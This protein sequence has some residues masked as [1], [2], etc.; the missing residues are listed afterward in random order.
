[1]ILRIKS[2]ID[3]LKTIQAFK[4]V[5]GVAEFSTDNVRLQFVPAA[6][7]IP[8][9]CEA[10]RINGE[11]SRYVNAVSQYIIDTVA[12]VIVARNVRDK[13]GEAVISDIEILRSAVMQKLIGWVPDGAACELLYRRG[14]SEGFTD[15]NLI[16]RDEYVTAHN[17]EN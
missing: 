2:I 8:L 15:Q 10:E 13:R 14:R 3:R 6:Y 17:V 7:V 5:G 4:I 16:W 1:M 12:V 9:E 11:L